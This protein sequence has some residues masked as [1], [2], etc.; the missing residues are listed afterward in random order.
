MGNLTAKLIETTINTLELVQREVTQLFGEETNNKGLNSIRTEFLSQFSILAATLHQKNTIKWIKNSKFVTDLFDEEIYTAG[1]RAD[2][3][4]NDTLYIIKEK[5]TL[6]D[7]HLEKFDRNGMMID[8]F[9]HL[10]SRKSKQSSANTQNDLKY[11]EPNR[12]RI[13]FNLEELRSKVLDPVRF[14]VQLE[15]SAGNKIIDF[16][17]TDKINEDEGFKESIARMC[18]LISWG[19]ENQ[20]SWDTIQQNSLEIASRLKDELGSL[21][22]QLFLYSDSFNK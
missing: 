1:Q 20:E 12:Q 15:I 5:I 13:L 2:T 21:K 3:I 18:E 11:S 17:E 4:Q 19:F 8:Q 14:T 6:L 9:I 16:F 22:S 7:K 10:I